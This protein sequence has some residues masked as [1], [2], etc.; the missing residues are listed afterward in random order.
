M[1]DDAHDDP[2]RKRAKAQAWGEL[3]A[4]VRRSQTLL[5]ATAITGLTS[6][7]TSVLVREADRA[8][9]SARE[10]D[11]ILHDE[12]AERIVSIEVTHR[13][14]SRLAALL[15]VSNAHYG[16]DS[17]VVDQAQHTVRAIAEPVLQAIELELAPENDETAR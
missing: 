10:L 6:A 13:Q 14:A 8:L 7:G 16:D 12:E 2:G 4:A 9:A 3:T 15:R 1:A 11:R 5:G 17:I